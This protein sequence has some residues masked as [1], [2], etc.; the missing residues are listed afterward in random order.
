MPPAIKLAI[1]PVLVK[2]IEVDKSSSISFSKNNSGE[3][4]YDIIAIINGDAIIHERILY[5][6]KPFTVFSFFE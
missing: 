3:N 2:R 5:I 4:A 6:L 1:T